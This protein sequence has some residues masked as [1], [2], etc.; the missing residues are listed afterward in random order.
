M[1]FTGRRPRCDGERR[2]SRLALDSL[3]GPS[4]LTSPHLHHHIPLTLLLYHNLAL[5]A[6][7]NRLLLAAL[8]GAVMKSM[9]IWVLTPYGK[10]EVRFA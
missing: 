6:Q 5:L 10:G 7:S 1:P 4:C 8:A 2:D 9:G 3:P